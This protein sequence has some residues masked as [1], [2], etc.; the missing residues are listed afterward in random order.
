MGGPVGPPTFF[1]QSKNLSHIGTASSK[2]ISLS[3]LSDLKVRHFTTVSSSK[4]GD[5]S[6]ITIK[7]QL[8]LHLRK[9][10]D[11]RKPA[12]LHEWPYP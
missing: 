4:N 3:L 1:H 2:N 6:I 12:T 9:F 8:A 7:N 10:G 11:R 5:E